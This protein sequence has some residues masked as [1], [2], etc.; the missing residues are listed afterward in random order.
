ME[1]DIGKT[2]EDSIDFLGRLSNSLVFAIC[3][4]AISS[5]PDEFKSEAAN[6]CISSIS[7][8]HKKMKDFM[9][10]SHNAVEFYLQTTDF[11]SRCIT[12]VSFF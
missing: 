4:I 3:C 10:Y 2:N 7:E 6:Q 1:L 11:L 9:R 12:E 8:I 5:D